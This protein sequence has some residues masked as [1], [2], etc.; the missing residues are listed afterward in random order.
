MKPCFHFVNIS[1][2]WIKQREG[3]LDI[4]VCRVQDSY[5]FSHLLRFSNDLF[6]GTKA[7]FTLQPKVTQF[8][9]LFCHNATC[10]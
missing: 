3:F 7:A 5:G 10:I 2:G 1:Q 8:Q 9:F 4:I 6:T